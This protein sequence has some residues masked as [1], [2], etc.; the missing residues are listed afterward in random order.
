M[1]SDRELEKRIF[2]ENKQKW[3]DACSKD[4]LSKEKTK[5][6]KV[7]NG[8]ILPLKKSD[9]STYSGKYMGGVCDEKF[10]FLGGLIRNI[11][12]KINYSCEEAYEVDKSEIKYYD[13]EIIFG[14]VII[15][16]FGHFILESLS[17]LWYLVENKSN[18]RIA[19]VIANNTYKTY[20]NDYFKLLDIDLEKIIYIESPSQ[21]KKVIIPDETIHAWSNYKKK[22]T[23]IY[24]KIMSNV[25]AKEHKKIYLT[26]T[27]F[28]KQDC[29]NEEYFEKFYEKRGYKIIAPEQYSIEEQIAYIK[30]AD[31][32]V[33]TLGSLS[34]LLLFAKPKTKLIIL[35]RANLNPLIPQ[36]LVN[37]SK[38][39]DFYIIDVSFNFLP[40]LHNIGCFLIGPSK[41]WKEYLNTINEKYT[42]EDV[43]MDISKFA[44]KYLIKWCE[45]FSVQ[46][47]WNYGLTSFDNFDI[48]NSLSK[49]LLDKPLKRKEYKNSYKDKEKEYKK[50]IE[51]LNGSACTSEDELKK[52][53]IKL[54]E[55]LEKIKNSKSWRITAPLR[56]ILKMI[57]KK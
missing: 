55:E 34:H 8:I 29:F 6:Q 44:Y 19:F 5:V 47:N 11:N 23:V 14:G 50:I 46:K 18:Y 48:L 27:Q 1:Y 57:K 21:F 39:L 35:A 9:S 54:K 30:G 24:E 3:I 53:N 45:T 43:T 38:K 13:E 56:K 15:S 40:V 22:Y 4:Y 52:E 28:E 20:F 33:C 16:T 10:N 41:Y 25:K 42:E 17:R 26:R 31:E 12:K 37:Q 32:V 7:K 2:T 49:V 36:L 51:N